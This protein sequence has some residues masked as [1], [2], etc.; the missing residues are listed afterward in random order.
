MNPAKGSTM[1]KLE[2][3]DWRGSAG[4]RWASNVDHFETMLTEI[5]AALLAHAG[6]SPG[7]TVVEIGCG[8]GR[9]TREIAGR[10][11]PDGTVTGVDISPTLVALATDRAAADDIGNISFT[12][13]D[14]QT[15]MPGQAPFDRLVSRFGVMFFADPAAAMANLRAMLKPGG[16]LDFA[17]WAPIA[18]NPWAATMMQAAR[19]PLGLVPPEPRAPGPFAFSEEDYLRGLL[20]GAG[21]SSV[22]ITPWTGSVKIGGPGA[23]AEEVAELSMMTGSIAE[24]LKDA[25]AELRAMVHRSLT[26]LLRPYVGPSGA[27]LPASVHLVTASA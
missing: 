1:A 23:T 12:A 10:V 7:E 11:A 20:E 19:E 26:E 27:V 24:P 22:S 2:P 25:S 3:A 5:G 9:L 8:G 6:F 13:I 17:V 16:R 21:F 15:G 18:G 4:D 14:A